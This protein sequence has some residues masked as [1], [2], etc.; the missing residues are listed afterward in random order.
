VQPS[1]YG[2]DNSLLLESLDALGGVGRGMW[3]NLCKSARR[4]IAAPKLADAIVRDNAVRLL[5][6]LESIMPPEAW[7]RSCSWP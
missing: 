7:A 6:I 2:I 1:F 4:T 3:I 5:W